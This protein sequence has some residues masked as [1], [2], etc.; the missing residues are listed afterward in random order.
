MNILDTRNLQEL[1][2]ELE[3]M[4]SEYALNQAETEKPQSWGEVAEDNAAAEAEFDATPYGEE[5]AALESLRDEIGREWAYGVQLIDKDDFE[6][7]A[8]ELA[9]ETGAIDRNAGWPLRHIDWEAAA[10]ELE[11]DYTS[12]EFLGTSYLFRA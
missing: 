2:E 8:Q 11:G 3:E 7:Y 4:K 12:V 9:E 1:T 10:R 6:A 5:L